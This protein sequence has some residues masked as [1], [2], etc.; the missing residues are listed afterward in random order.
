MEEKMTIKE[1]IKEMNYPVD[2]NLRKFIKENGLKQNYI[3]EKAGY[4]KQE[5]SYMLNGR[6]L[7]KPLDVLR[8]A[9]VLGTDAN[10]L[11]GLG[12]K[13]KLI[14]GGK[15][16]EEIQVLTDED[17]LICSISKDDIIEK[18]GYRV[19]CSAIKN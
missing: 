3:A 1:V 16:Y 7:I 2:I 19:V 11:Y 18:K 13:E 10:L 6:K 17:E 9:E 8:L 12:S 5:L 15:E 4:S 14:I